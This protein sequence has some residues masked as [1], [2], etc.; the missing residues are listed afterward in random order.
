MVELRYERIQE[1]FFPYS[2][3]NLVLADLLTSLQA[4]R[5][6]L[7]VANAPLPLPALLY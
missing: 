5:F 6:A 2:L 7:V 1:I 4:H 3:I